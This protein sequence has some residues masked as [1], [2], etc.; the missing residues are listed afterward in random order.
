MELLELFKHHYG[1]GILIA[2]SIQVG[3]LAWEYTD[4]DSL[5]DI[6]GLTVIAGLLSL[7]SWVWVWIL[8]IIYT[9]KYITGRDDK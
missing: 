1:L 5:E 9:I 2:F 4:E 8:G 3:I 6:V 7:L